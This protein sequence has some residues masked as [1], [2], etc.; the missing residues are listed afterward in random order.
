MASVNGHSGRLSAPVAAIL[1]AGCMSTPTPLPEDQGVVRRGAVE[2]ISAGY[3]HIVDKYLEPI[4][5]RSVALD[6]LSG[7]SA[8]DPT[9]KVDISDDS[10]ALRS[11]RGVIGRFSMPSQDDAEAWATLTLDV[12]SAGRRSSSTLANL[13][14]ERVYEAVF[15]G[16][17]RELDRFTDYAGPT[18]ADRTRAQRDGVGGVGFQ[19][20]VNNGVP[21]VTLVLPETPSERAGVR[22]TD[23]LTQIDGES[24]KDMSLA[25]LAEKLRG[26]VG[27]S[28]RLA[29]ERAS[30]SRSIEMTVIRSLIVPRT[31]TPQER[32]GILVL[33]VSS[34]NQNTAHSFADRI[35]QARERAGSPPKGLVI[36]LRG[37][38]GGLLDQAIRMADLLLERGAIIDQRGRNIL[39]TRHYEASGSD[40]S[41]GMPVVV[42]IDGRSASAAEV[43]TAALQDQKRA[44]VIGTTS[45]GKG[46]VQTVLR[47][48][49]DG[50]MTLTWSR[51]IAPS[52]YALHDLGIHPSIC[53]SGVGTSRQPLLL[54]ANTSEDERESLAFAAWR[55]VPVNDSNGREKLRSSCPAETRTGDTELDLAIRLL[56][57]RSLYDRYIGV[58]VM[59]DALSTPSQSA[60]QAPAGR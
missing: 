20:V 44:V 10:L 6:S 56:T 13:P 5:V 29:F 14:M 25:K 41:G 35:T 50:E 57:D 60:S 51:L 46:T 42:L 12:Y 55:R 2:T 1:L 33:K 22:A 7:V 37:N 38:P 31:I 32:D 53:T 40:V 28:V 24:T 9:F 39:S 30:E 15:K 47:L 16:A 17:V 21:R 45:Y 58:T 49:N 34:F 18:D 19:Y 36:D 48:P 23:V 4:S 54:A 26:R 52:G 59:A 3:F 11:D 8:L 43:L 27:S